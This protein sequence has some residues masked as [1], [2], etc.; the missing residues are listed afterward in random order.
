MTITACLAWYRETPESLDRCVRSLAGVCDRLIAL[1]GRWELFP[2]D[3]FL[4]TDEER[5]AV[6]E[7]ARGAHVAG[8][9][10]SPAKPFASQ[11]EK[12]ALLMTLAADADW[13]L[14]IDGDEHLRCPDP[15]A[16]RTALA[17]TDAD[18]CRVNLRNYGGGVTQG[19]RP[20]RRVYRASTGVTVETAHNGYRTADGRWLHGDPAYAK[21]LERADT[22]EDLLTVEHDVDARPSDRRAAAKEYRRERSRDRVEAWA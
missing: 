10:V 11:V 12:R 3:G 6:L 21:P 9:L 13:L 22:L 16:F 8:M 15:N 17:E 4:S 18:V 20:V 19:E 1:D 7:A 5:D 14:V 2:G